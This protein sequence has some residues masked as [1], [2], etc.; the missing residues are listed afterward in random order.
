MLREVLLLTQ[1]DLKNVTEKDKS[2]KIANNFNEAYKKF[3][4]AGI[5]IG[6]AIKNLSIASKK[7]AGKK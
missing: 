4:N 2:I 1:G 5:S 3:S 6:E 7:I